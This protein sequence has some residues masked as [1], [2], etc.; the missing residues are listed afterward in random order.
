MAKRQ[1]GEWRSERLLLVHCGYAEEQAVRARSWHKAGIYG[2][3]G[4]LSQRTIGE[5]G[6]V[7]RGCLV[8][9]GALGNSRP[10]T[11]EPQ[12]R[13]PAVADIIGARRVWTAAMISS[14]SMP[15]R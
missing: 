10:W 4:R 9:A 8:R 6:S 14:V 13:R 7:R 5:S 2:G 1:S 3:P 11:S 12:S 15:C